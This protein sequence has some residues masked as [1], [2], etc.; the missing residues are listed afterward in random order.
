MYPRQ[1][2]AVDLEAQLLLGHPPDGVGQRFAETDGAARDVPEAL[3]R[4]GVAASEQ[5][6][7]LAT[8]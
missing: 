1:L 5:D 8:R 6:P 7:G 2:L 3:A 4:P